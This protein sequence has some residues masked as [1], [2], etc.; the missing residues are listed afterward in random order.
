MKKKERKKNFFSLIIVR[1]HNDQCFNELEFVHNKKKTI[2]VV[3]VVVVV[4]VW[5][6]WIFVM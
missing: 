6:K 5:C 4:V 2:D 3:V 1:F